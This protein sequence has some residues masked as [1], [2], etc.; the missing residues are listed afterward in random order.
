MRGKSRRT[1][2]REE[3]FHCRRKKGAKGKSPAG[4]EGRKGFTAGEKKARKVRVLQ[5]EKGGK[6]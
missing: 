5:E 3:R 6:V 2:R 1:R 4:G